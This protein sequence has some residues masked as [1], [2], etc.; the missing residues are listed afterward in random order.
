MAPLSCLHVVANTADQNL[1]VDE[2]VVIDNA[3]G[4]GQQKG[5]LLRFFIRG[6]RAALHQEIVIGRDR[7][8]GFARDSAL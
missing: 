7:G 2:K 5:E 6:P 1:A 3:G 4:D 8:L